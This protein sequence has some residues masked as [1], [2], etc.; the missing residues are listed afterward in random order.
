MGRGGRGSNSR[1]RREPSFGSGRGGEDLRLRPE[2]RANPPRRSGAG[3][4]TVKAV[5]ERSAVRGR[6]PAAGRGG[7]GGRSRKR[8]TGGRSLMGRLFVWA[9][10]LGVWGM[11]GL[12]GLV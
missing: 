5:A 11:I 3:P 10:T 7:G 12:A 6:R 9:V 2:D 1:M 4:Q 8:R